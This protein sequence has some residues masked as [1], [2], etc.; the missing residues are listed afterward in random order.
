M[1]YL[2]NKNW[3]PSGPLPEKN[4]K[5]GWH[6]TANKY[7]PHTQ[8]SASASPAT[9]YL[10]SSDALPPSPCCFSL[11][12]AWPL[13]TSAARGFL[14]FL[15]TQQQPRSSAVTTLHLHW[16]M[17]PEMNSQ[18]IMKFWFQ[19]WKSFLWLKQRLFTC[20]DVS[21]A[22]DELVKLPLW[23]ES[24]GGTNFTK[25]QSPRF[26]Y[27]LS[28]VGRLGSSQWNLAPLTLSWSLPSRP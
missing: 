15:S 6:S 21:W 4:V 7:S 12:L 23:Q 10:A 5:M 14:F 8:S 18:C 13:T 20:S 24:E 17:T 28:L 27:L 2:Q 3:H 9:S 16:L 26:W 22:G 1:F 11:N 19:D 25:A